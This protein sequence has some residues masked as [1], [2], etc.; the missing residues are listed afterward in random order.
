MLRKLFQ[1]F[2]DVLAVGRE[3]A[4]LA[5]MMRELEAERAKYRIPAGHF[6]PNKQ[7]RRRREFMYR[8]PCQPSLQRSGK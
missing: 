3:R 8:H 7:R 2:R 6:N 4:R 5:L 1:W